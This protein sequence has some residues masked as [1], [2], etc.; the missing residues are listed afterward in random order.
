MTTVD[1]KL[2]VLRQ[3]KREHNIVHARY[4]LTQAQSPRERAFW[5][6]IL[7]RLEG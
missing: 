2:K 1:I 4:Q 3:W 5:E 7:E 6:L